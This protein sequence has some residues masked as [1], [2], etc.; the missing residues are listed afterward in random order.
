M[1]VRML[2]TVKKNTQRKINLSEKYLANEKETEKKRT[3]AG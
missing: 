2:L 3:A 1:A